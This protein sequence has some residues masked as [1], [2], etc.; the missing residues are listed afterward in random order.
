MLGPDVGKRYLRTME[1][2]IALSDPAVEVSVTLWLGVIP[3]AGAFLQAPT[4]LVEDGAICSTTA[5][6]TRPK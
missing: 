2:H 6:D 4:A 5:C 3:A 1:P